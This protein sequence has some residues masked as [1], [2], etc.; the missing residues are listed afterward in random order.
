LGKLSFLSKTKKEREL[1]N[2]MNTCLYFFRNTCLY[3]GTIKL[4]KRDIE[5]NFNLTIY[6]HSKQILVLGTL[7][8]PAKKIPVSA[9]M[10][11]INVTK[12]AYKND[13]L[14]NYVTLKTISYFKLSKYL[15]ILLF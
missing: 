13:F 12:S 9:L 1:K 8:Y 3:Q 2:T 11:L 15:T 6:F 14:K 5:E 4:I 10:K 7:K